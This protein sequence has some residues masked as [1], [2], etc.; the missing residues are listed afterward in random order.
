MIVS[1]DPIRKD[2]RN[3]AYIYAAG[4]KDARAI[5]EA[6]GMTN[7]LETLDRDFY[8]TVTAFG[9]AAVLS[10]AAEANRLLPDLDCS[11]F[12]VLSLE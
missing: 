6:N 10:S 1:F 3:D 9:A 5:V 8:E 2:I 4:D 12:N 11:R 7:N